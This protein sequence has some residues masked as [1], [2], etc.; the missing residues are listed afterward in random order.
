MQGDGKDMAHIK[1]YLRKKSPK[2]L[3]G[4]KRPWQKRYFVLYS[5]RLEYFKDEKDKAYT[6]QIPVRM[7]TN[8]EQLYHKADGCRFD[9]TIE[10]DNVRVFSLKTKDTNEAKLWVSEIK[11]ILAVAAR[12]P[13]RIGP[14]IA[15]GKT[16]WKNK[17]TLRSAMTSTK[18]HLEAQRTIKARDE[19]A[20]DLGY[21]C[22]NMIRRLKK[23]FGSIYQISHTK[24]KFH[25]ILHMVPRESD[26]AKEIF[27]MF[28][29]EVEN[30]TPHFMNVVEH[31]KT[32]DAYWSIYENGATSLWTHL[33]RQ[34]K[35]P[36]SKAR[37]FAAEICVALRHE[38]QAGRAVLCLRPE[39]V[40]LAPSGRVVLA[41]L[42]HGSEELRAAARDYKTETTEYTTPD[43]LNQKTDDQVS[44]W[45]RLGCI[46][47]EMLYG[48][49]PFVSLRHTRNAILASIRDFKDKPLRFPRD[50][51]TAAKSFI[52]S[53]LS[54]RK[55]REK[56]QVWENVVREP[57]FTGVD[58]RAIRDNEFKAQEAR[59][60]R[61]AHGTKTKYDLTIA[62]LGARDLRFGPFD[63]SK[64]VLASVQGR[65]TR[66]VPYNS[67][68]LSFSNNV[69]TFSGIDEASQLSVVTIARGN[70]PGDSASGTADIK[71]SDC[72]P[73]SGE[74]IVG[75]ESKNWIGLFSSDSRLVGD[76][77]IS[78]R[79]DK[80]YKPQM[81]RESN[82]TFN[83]YFAV[84]QKKVMSSTLP[85]DMNRPN[86]DEVEDVGR[87]SAMLT[88]DQSGSFLKKGLN[89]IRNFSSGKKKRWQQDGYDL[90][91]SYIT[92]RLIAMGYPSESIKQMYRNPIKEVQRFFRSRHK[93]EHKV[94]NLCSEGKYPKDKF[95]AVAEYPI[96]DHQVPPLKMM[97][98]FCLDVDQF[99]TLDQKN[100]AVVHCKSGKGRTGIM[101]CAY[102]Q[103]A[104]ICPS[105]DTAIKLFDYNRMMSSD[106]GG[107]I[108]GVAIPSQKR[109]IKYFDKYLKEYYWPAKPRSF[110]F[111]GRPLILH[112][113]RL[114]DFGD[115]K[116][117]NFKVSDIR[118]RIVFDSE[119]QL[120]PAP[121][122]EPDTSMDGKGSRKNRY[123]EIA[124]NFSLSGDVKLTLCRAK[125]EV[126]WMWL[127][128]SFIE[129][130]HVVLRKDEIDGAARDTNNRVF[131]ATMQVEL[132]FLP[133]DDTDILKSA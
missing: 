21:V 25:G 50:A 131:P 104:Q 103:F 37:Q 105:A 27:R 64:H 78:I 123:S 90:D 12:E 16:P 117:V 42:W 91:L 110:S 88:D 97:L 63:E 71:I 129:N 69:F 31:G 116:Q 33:K 77:E 28:R 39:N 19:Y 44:D 45:W 20:K 17:D 58:F 47:Y 125:S 40:F 36:E 41:D 2:T 93:G 51:S 48:L 84:T 79:F 124:C 102:I 99:L 82:F 96:D 81:C 14:V 23:G 87:L 52:C 94:Y 92:P 111:A 89:V 85:V 1:G 75:S 76:L 113:I 126:C 10:A 43:F 73:P 9:I 132:F 128:T 34:G 46:L 115:Y 70:S 5:D 127:N 59:K 121:V 38:H 74:P 108:P 119:R 101:L 80:I 30:D 29:N 60:Y 112:H 57:F 120:T 109:Y 26:R 13:R 114:T 18:R 95:E 65:V 35:F 55:T 118:R 61:Q 4:M 72:L 106:K 67:S 32:S 53:L 49:P 98:D 7:I 8:V 56:Y 68:A 3:F 54:D 24:N 130:N 66:S 11:K 86:D 6:G 62:L 15:G 22:G 107:A 83:N 133:K 100:V 122:F